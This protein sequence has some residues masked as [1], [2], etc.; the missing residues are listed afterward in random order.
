MKGIFFFLFL[1]SPCGHYGQCDSIV[2]KSTGL[3]AGE[4]LTWRAIAGGLMLAL[5][6]VKRQPC[7]NAAPARGFVEGDH[8]ESR[9]VKLLDG[10]V[11]KC[12]QMA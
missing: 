8:G 4:N 1:F 3:G 12:L 2:H 7:A 6:V 9:Q 11:H 5:L 10:E